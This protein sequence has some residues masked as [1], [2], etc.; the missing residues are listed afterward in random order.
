MNNIE[1]CLQLST[2]ILLGLG[3]A[4]N[5]GAKRAAAGYHQVH[6]NASVVSLGRV[7][8]PHTRRK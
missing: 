4:L 6:E 1:L 3:K 7:S 8:Y 5:C 2:A